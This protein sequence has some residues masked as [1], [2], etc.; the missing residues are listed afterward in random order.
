MKLTNKSNLFENSIKI[1]IPHLK[2]EIPLFIVFRA[3]G[4]ISDKEIIYHI[5]DNDK[6]K[7]DINIIKMLKCS[8]LESSEINT[9]AEAIDYISNYINNNNNYIVQSHDKKIKYVR[10][11]IINDYLAVECYKRF[12]WIVT[13]IQISS[14]ALT[15]LSRRCKSCSLQGHSF[16]V[17]CLHS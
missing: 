4:C 15:T 16:S 17:V 3:L 14:Q 7:I 5:I 2:Q 9:E 8:I 12:Q 13:R 1:A 6:S 10:E 11:T